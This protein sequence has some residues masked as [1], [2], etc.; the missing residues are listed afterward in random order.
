MSHSSLPT[1]I[2]P[3]V[4]LRPPRPEDWA[5]RFALGNSPE[6]HRLFGGDPA[7]F[8]PL[9][10]DAARAWVDTQLAER[11]A[12]IIE[13]DQRLIG[14]VRLHSVNYADHRAVLAIG[15]LDPVSLGQGYGAEAIRLVAGHAFGPMGLH[16]I[17][18]RVLEFNDRAIAA[19][20]KVGFVEEGRER[21][22]AFIGGQWHDDIL[23]G[24]LP[25]D[26]QQ[27]DAA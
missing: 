16:R 19:Y 22:S 21:E 13:L 27:D 1:L 18:L 24:L 6:L 5:G 4:Q 2:G 20:R 10:E 3:R 23:M 17:S 25:S 12:W 8:R 9:T 7:Q 14:A 15:I 26:L 11:F